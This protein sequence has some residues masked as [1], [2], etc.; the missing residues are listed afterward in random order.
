MMSSAMPSEK[1]SCSASPD[2]LANARTAIDRPSLARAGG[3]T[4]GA[5]DEARILDAGVALPDL[6]DSDPVLP[7]VAEVILVGELKSFAVFGNDLADLGH[8][9]ID[10][11][12]VLESVVQ[13]LGIAVA[14]AVDLELVQMGVRPAHRRLNV[15]VELVE[16]AVLDLNPTPD[17]GLGFEQCDL[18]L[19]QAFGGRD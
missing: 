12:E 6:T 9:G 16:R 10:A 11:L 18:E 7:V 15:F 1:Y 5:G 4:A 3:G 8:G 17:R 14:F 13:K 19:V 2:M